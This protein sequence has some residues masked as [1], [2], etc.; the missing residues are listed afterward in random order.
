MNR[1]KLQALFNY[2][3]KQA[4]ADSSNATD[5]DSDDEMPQIMRD[6]SKEFEID[7]TPAADD[8]PE[9]I[10]LTPCNNDS[11]SLVI[12][13]NQIEVYCNGQLID[14]VTSWADDFDSYQAA[15]TSYNHLE[16]VLDGKDYDRLPKITITRN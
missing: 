10:T 13:G 7:Y 16:K 4:A 14:I 2:A 8:A 12:Q 11:V 1:R 5:E 15:V 9:L 6:I 3:R